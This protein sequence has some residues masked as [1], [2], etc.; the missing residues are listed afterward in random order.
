MA[1]LPDAMRF[2]GVEQ[3]RSMRMSIAD[4]RGNADPEILDDEIDDD[5][6]GDADAEEGAFGPGDDEMPDG[7][8]DDD[9]PVEEAA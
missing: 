5:A 8:E 2:D 7:A 6:G 9:H 4:E 3:P 1:W